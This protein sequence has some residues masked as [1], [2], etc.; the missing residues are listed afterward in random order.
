MAKKKKG[1]ASLIISLICLVLSMLLIATF[2]MPTFAEKTEDGY[3]YNGVVLTQA[4]FMSEDDLKETTVNAADFF[5]YSE[6]ER[7]EFAKTIF[8]YSYLHDE[9]S[10]G[11]KLATITNWVVIVVGAVGVILSVLALINKGNGL[12]LI[13]TALLAVIGSAALLILASTYSNHVYEAAF[14]KDLATLSVGVGTWIAMV[15]SVLLFGT[16]VAGKIIKK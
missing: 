12:G 14:I 10:A 4:F 3:K 16:S 2:F 6:E 1:L 15:S 5:E 11:F 13:F 9:E 7:E 8:A